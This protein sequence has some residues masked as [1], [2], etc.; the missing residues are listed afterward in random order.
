MSLTCTE[1]PAGLADLS[2]AD[3]GPER[4]AELAREI[5]KHLTHAS[6]E[7][8]ILNDET[9]FLSINAQIEAARAGGRVGAAFGVV[10]SAIQDLSGKAAGVSC[11]LSSKTA[12]PL[13]ELVRMSTAI[14]DRLSG[15]RLVGAAEHII[16]VID[17][18]LYERSCDCRWWATDESTVAALTDLND[19]T[20]K[21]ACNRL[22]VI[23]DSYTVYSDL[24]LCDLQGR[25]IAH[26]R[27]GE[28]ASL[29]LI[30]SQA[31][32]FRE[33]LGTLD[34]REYS[35]ESPHA[36]H[37]ARSQRVMIFAAA[38]RE[39]G[40][41]HG[42]PI[43]VLAAVFNWD[44]LGQHL[45]ENLPPDIAADDKVRCMITTSVGKILADSNP[46]GLDDHIFFPG[47]DTVFREVS[48]YLTAE[49]EGQPR[50]IAHARSQGFETYRSGWH[51]LILQ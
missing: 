37:L 32:W 15:L 42:R 4:I 16:D 3:A 38:V 20:A 21:R 13:A 19:R 49:F 29:G 11:A 9:R 50:L 18:N 25:I 48:G 46:A 39:R 17:R 12:K 36:S 33:A 51:A 28:H 41:I 27:P 6:Q 47:R 40:E 5:L 22:S 2:T 34:G 14:S 31:L 7:I 26:G 8:R 23:L 10:A 45:V 30:C 24:I 44:A 1:G 43:G 35:S